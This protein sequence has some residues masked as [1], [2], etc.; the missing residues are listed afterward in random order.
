MVSIL[1]LL[2]I[3]SFLSGGLMSLL[4]SFSLFDQLVQSVSVSRLQL[5]L[6][7]QVSSLL[8]SVIVSLLLQGGVMLDQGLSCFLF[9]TL[10]LSFEGVILADEDFLER[11]LLALE[12]L[13]L[14]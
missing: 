4:V 7:S 14:L 1:S 12:F 6:G 13:N 5:V 11:L 8:L 10:D 9:K 2:F 3:K